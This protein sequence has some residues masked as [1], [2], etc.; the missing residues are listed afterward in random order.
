MEARNLTQTARSDNKLH[1]VL[2][3]A[4]VDPKDCYQCGK[5]SAGCPVASDADMTPREV[6][7]HLQL[8]QVEPVLKSNMPWLC[9]GCGMC[10]VRCPQSVDLPN[11]M[12]ACRRAAEVQGI[13]PIGEVARFNQLFING[14]REKGLSDEAVLAMRFNLTTGHF[15][16]DILSAP[17][18]VVR[19]MIGPTSKEQAN[20]D[21]VK[22]LIDRARMAASQNTPSP[23]KE[24]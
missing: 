3:D 5:C 4:K 7:R 16:Q 22:E 20:A 24:A 13:E 12:L 18:M 1:S 9:A 23:E 10:L 19:G 14:V 15:L 17:K 21:E 6:L 2:G 8:R 11:L